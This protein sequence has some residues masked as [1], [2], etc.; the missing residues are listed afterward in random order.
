MREALELSSPFST[1]NPWLAEELMPGF[2]A[3]L[4]TWWKACVSVA[5]QLYLSLGEALDTPDANQ[6]RRIHGTYDHLTW[7]YYASTSSKRLDSAG[8]SKRLG[9]HTDFGTLTLL[10]QD[11]VGGL[12]LR[13]SDDVFR[14]VVPLEGAIV[15]NSGDML[16]HLSNGRWKSV[17]H[18][19]VA[20]G[21]LIESTSQQAVV[22]EDEVADRYSL[23]FFGVPNADVQ[24]QQMPGCEVPGR[25]KS[26]MALKGSITAGQWVREG[27]AL[28]Y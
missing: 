10:F 9:A 11:T 16:G 17:F 6:L 15:V 12:E 27:L 19:V 21:D 3:F 23:V 18:R 8:D 26:N 2:R 4:E 14:P 22:S 7:N 24:I 5:D 20:P 13:D 28:E 25:W 1:T